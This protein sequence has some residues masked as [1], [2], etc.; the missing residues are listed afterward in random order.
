MTASSVAARDAF[1]S[2][3][4][5]RLDEL[6]IPRRRQIHWFRSAWRNETGERL[7]TTCFRKWLS[8]DSLPR[9][10]RLPVLARLIGLDP[11]QLHHPAYTT[12]KAPTTAVIPCL[13]IGVLTKCMEDIDYVLA[14]TGDHISTPARAAVVSALYE[15]RVQTRRGR[16]SNTEK[17]VMT[18]FSLVRSQC[19]WSNTG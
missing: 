13:D 1:A 17:A 3:L 9:P 5:S 8:G 14:Q 6:G 18:L 2:R 12:V 15:Q 11:S 4:Q 10:E 19:I 16:F 7:S